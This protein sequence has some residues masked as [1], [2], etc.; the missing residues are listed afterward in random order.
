MHSLDL[1]P[2][3][4]YTSREIPI[5]Y[6]DSSSSEGVPTPLEVPQSPSNFLNHPP[7]AP[8][9]I[10]IPNKITQPLIGTPFITDSASLFEYP[11]PPVSSRPPLSS[12]S[13]SSSVA[14]IPG[15]PS[16][17]ILDKHSSHS[18]GL[19]PIPIPPRLRKLSGGHI[20]DESTPTRHDIPTPRFDLS[21]RADNKFDNLQGRSEASPN[22]DSVAARTDDPLATRAYST[23]RIIPGYELGPA[24]SSTPRTCTDMS[25]T[26][27]R[28]SMP[29]VLTDSDDEHTDFVSPGTKEQTR[30]RF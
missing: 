11:F 23:P 19:S 17:A 20:L 13:S 30:L 14:S 28:R 16:P 8:L 4:T 10:D 7:E 24:L 6:E 9:S 3:R 1:L 25:I 5:G 12:T 2:V 26:N 29:I 18:R 22:R 21:P 27:R 15:P